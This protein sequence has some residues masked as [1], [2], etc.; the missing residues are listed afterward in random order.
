MPIFQGLHSVVLRAAHQKK[1]LSRATR[2]EEIF[3]QKKKLNEKPNNTVYTIFQQMA[4]VLIKLCI[5]FVYVQL[6]APRKT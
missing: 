6:T 3:N 2:V 4:L 1:N 5:H